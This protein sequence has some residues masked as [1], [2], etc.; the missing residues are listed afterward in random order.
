VY[1][2]S[3]FI[4]AVRTLSS[5]LR[6]RGSTLA[7]GCK[8][9]Q[10]RVEQ[11]SYCSARVEWSHPKLPLHVSEPVPASVLSAHAT[12]SAGSRLRKSSVTD[13]GQGQAGQPL[14]HS[15]SMMSS[16]ASQ[17]RE[18]RPREPYPV[19]SNNPSSQYTLLEKLGTGSFGV[20][21][22]AI[23]NETKQIVAIKQIGAS[24]CSM[25]CWS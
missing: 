13:I 24:W 20:V 1:L 9:F 15:P 7:K 17:D 23:H 12:M 14:A 6:E 21:Y 18:S 4:T 11:S 8:V 25:L 5:S 22:K 10:T 16:Q 2:V 19:P 3:P